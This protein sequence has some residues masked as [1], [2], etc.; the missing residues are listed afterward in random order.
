MSRSKKLLRDVESVWRELLFIRVVPVD[1][2]AVAS[3]NARRARLCSS[4]TALPRMP[5]A[6]VFGQ[7]TLKKSQPYNPASLLCQHFL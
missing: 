6:T 7:L 3:E 1:L 5:D 2:F 4:D